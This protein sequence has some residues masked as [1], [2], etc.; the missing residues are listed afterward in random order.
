[1][2]SVQRTLKA[3][4]ALGGGD[5]AAARRCAGDAVATTGAF[6]SDALTT[7]ACVAIAQGEPEQGER[8][9][10]DALARAAELEA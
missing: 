10:H 1:M 2:S 5:L 4:A 9:A 7:R 8:D 3:E 6:L